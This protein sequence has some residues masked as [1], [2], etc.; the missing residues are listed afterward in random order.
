MNMR[1]QTGIASQQ[2]SVGKSLL[3]LA[4]EFA[5]SGDNALIPA[6]L[7]AAENQGEVTPHSL[8]LRAISYLNLGNYS[9]FWAYIRRAEALAPSDLNIRQTI[10]LMLS[11]A[12]SYTF[13]SIQTPMRIR[14][15]REFLHEYP[16]RGV[17]SEICNLVQDQETRALQVHAINDVLVAGQEGSIIDPQTATVFINSFSSMAQ[18]SVDLTTIEPSMSIAISEAIALPGHVA[19]LCGRWSGNF[20]H[21][22]AELLP[23]AFL[24]HRAGFQGGYMIPNCQHQFIIESLEMIGIPPYKLTSNDPEH[25]IR[26]ETLLTFDSFWY[27]D[28]Y[29]NEWIMDSMIRQLQ[30]NIDTASPLP[31]N[32]RGLYIMRRG[33]RAVQNQDE[34]LELLTQHGVLGIYAED[35]SFGEQVRLASQARLIF[36]AHGAGLSL[37]LF[38]PKGSTLVEFV[39]ADS[40]NECYDYVAQVRS[41]RHILIPTSPKPVGDI[42]NRVE[43]SLRLLRQVLRREL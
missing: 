19:H 32:S 42:P 34:V 4:Q 10:D 11:T 25:A 21:W 7:D 13:D 22:M 15:A 9:G 35:L 41:H 39:P 36:G 5:R 40:L 30:E 37:G 3:Y 18:R 26:C 33:N 17:S 12:S 16:S 28:H 29:G 2:S 31:H 20:F 43:P 6:L 27:D 8:L 23:R 1:N 24:L 14:D 38:M